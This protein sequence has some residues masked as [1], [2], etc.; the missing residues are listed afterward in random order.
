MIDVKTLCDILTDG[1][2]GQG[3]EPMCIC[4][5]SCNLIFKGLNESGRKTKG[6]GEFKLMQEPMGHFKLTSRR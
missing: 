2:E 1:G 4:P 5:Q 6:P 3:K